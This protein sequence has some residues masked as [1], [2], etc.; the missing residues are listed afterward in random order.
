M[1]EVKSFGR[2]LSRYRIVIILHVL[3]QARE[4]LSTVFRDPTLWLYSI[5][6]RW[7]AWTRERRTCR[8][9]LLYERCERDDSELPFCQEADEEVEFVGGSTD[10]SV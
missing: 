8:L 7:R 10:D 9:D 2:I 3:L 4:G 5:M 1:V 6:G